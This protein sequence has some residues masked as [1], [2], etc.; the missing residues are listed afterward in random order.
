MKLANQGK[1]KVKALPFK[2]E[3]RKQTLITV[4]N[5]VILSLIIIRALLI[6]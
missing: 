3:L 4:I 6:A 1:I 5:Y 2:K